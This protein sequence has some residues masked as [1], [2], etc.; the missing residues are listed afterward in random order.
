MEHQFLAI[1]D[2]SQREDFLPPDNRHSELV[3][4]LIGNGRQRGKAEYHPVDSQRASDHCIPLT[5]ANLLWRIIQ[6][7]PLPR[8]SRN[9][10]IKQI[11]LDYSSLIFIDLFEKKLDKIIYRASYG[12]RV[13]KLGYKA[14]LLMPV[15]PWP[16]V[17]TSG[18]LLWWARNSPISK[19]HFG[20][21]MFPSPTATL[22]CRRAP[23]HCDTGPLSLRLIQAFAVKRSL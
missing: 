18:R 10:G 1:D 17:M 13:P 22:V 16:A 6:I 4:E 3:F 15:L 2:N 19:A 12:I 21:T 20:T 11:Y 5:S 8:I 9:R 7:V 14:L 23:F